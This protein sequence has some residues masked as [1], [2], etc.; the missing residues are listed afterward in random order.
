[1][2]HTILPLPQQPS[3]QTTR[4][5]KYDI[6]LPGNGAARSEEHT[7]EL[8]SQAYLVCRLLLEKTKKHLF[9]L[10]CSCLG[11]V[12]YRVESIQGFPFPL[13]ASPTIVTDRRPNSLGR[14]WWGQYPRQPERPT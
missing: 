2:A 7:S 13:E 4:P 11:K 3:S 6:P 9:E 5:L 8:Q 14:C 10:G 1:M 12:L